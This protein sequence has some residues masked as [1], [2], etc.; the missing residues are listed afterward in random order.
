MILVA[1]SLMIVP[2]F[3]TDLMGFLLL[4]PPVRLGVFRYLRS[5]TTVTQFSMR[6]RGFSAQGDVIDGDFTEVRPKSDPNTPPSGWV[7]GPDNR[8]K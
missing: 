8:T 7:E 6:S 5:K 1:G 2:G 3:F 4:L